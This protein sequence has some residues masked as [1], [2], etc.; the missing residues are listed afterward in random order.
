MSNQLI[1]FLF[2]IIPL[3]TILLMK[4]QDIKRFMPVTLFT[5]FTSGII[6]QIGIIAGV[7]YFRE[8]AFPFVMYGFLPAVAAWIFRFTYGRFWLY[9]LTNAIIDIGF[10]FILFPWF[11]RRGILGIGPWTS[12]IVYLINF[13]HASILYIYQIWQETIF[14]LSL[15]KRSE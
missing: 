12:I 6:Y 14:A 13:V 5:A 2:L 4:K 9:I 3:L 15:R 1:L 10:A 8:I 7:W 11:D